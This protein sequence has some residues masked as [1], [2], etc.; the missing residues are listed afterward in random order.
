[1]KKSIVKKPLSLL[2]SLL[3]MLSV[4]GCLAFTASAAQ[5][6]ATGTC[7]A[8]LTWELDLEGTLTVRGTGD[9]T[10]Y[11]IG[12]F[13]WESIK[14]KIRNVIVK[15]GVTSVAEHAFRDNGSLSSLV[16][17]GHITVFGGTAACGCG[18]LSYV[19]FGT[20]DTLASWA[21]SGDSNLRTMFVTG[22]IGSIGDRVFNAVPL[23]TIFGVPGTA[24]KS[25]AAS[26][27]V[28]FFDI[29]EN[30]TTITY[31]NY[32]QTLVTDVTLIASL[33]AVSKSWASYRYYASVDGTSTA[34]DWMRF[35]DFVC[36][37][38]KY[39]AV[40]FDAYRPSRADSVHAA[41][42]SNQDENGYVPGTVYYFKYEPIAW[43]ILDS[44]A[45]LLLS[46]AILDAQM[47]ALD[48]A[49]YSESPIRAWL[50]NDFYGTAFTNGQKENLREQTLDND[51][52]SA[53]MDKVWLPSQ[54]DLTNSAY[55]FT[56]ADNTQSPTRS[57]FGTDYAKCMGL[58]VS[59]SAPCYWH[60][61]S[62]WHLRGSDKIVDFS[63]SFSSGT[64][65]VSEYGVR[66]MICLGS[67]TSDV[68]TDS[69]S[70]SAAKHSNDPHAFG[71]VWTFDV[72]Q[73]T[74]TVKPACICC[75]Y[76]SSDSTSVDTALPADDVFS[77]SAP[78]G[79]KLTG[80]KN[81]STGTT[82]APGDSFSAI[83][84]ETFTA[85]WSDAYTVTFD[86]NGGS[87]IA[88]QLVIPY[89]NAIEPEAPV[90]DGFAFRG[91]KRD[92]YTAM[93]DFSSYVTENIMLRAEWIETVSYGS[94]RLFSGFTATACSGSLTSSEGGAKLID[95]DTGTKWC[96][97]NTESGWIEF[98]SNEAF[99]PTAYVL[100]TGNDTASFPKRNPLSWSV[101]AKKESTDEWVPLE[102][103]VKD[104]RL[105]AYN[106]RAFTYPL[107]GITESY[108]YFR[109][110]FYKLV[111][112]QIFQ[113]SEF[114]FRGITASDYKH[115]INCIVNGNVLTAT[116]SN[117]PCA[118][119]TNPLTLTLNAPT[120]TVYGDSGD[121][122]ATLTGLDTFNAQLGSSIT[123][124]SI[125]YSANGSTTYTAPTNAGSYT[126]LLSVSVNGSSYTIS[127][128]YIIAK[129]TP[130][131][132][133][134]TGL[135]AAYGDTLANVTLPEGWAW[136]DAPETSVGNAGE[137]T[138][139]ATFTPA[140]TANYNTVSETLTVAVA[141][142]APEYT[143]PEGLT[144][145][146]GKTL[147][148]IE[149]P[150]GW[151][152]N[153]APETPVGCLGEHTFTAT[154]TPEDTD[155]YNTAEAEI[156]V[157]VYTDYTFVPAKEPTCI[158]AGNS[159]Y[160]Y[161]PANRTYYVVTE[162][163][164]LA[165]IELYTTVIP[166]T[167]HIYGTVGD[168]RFTCT[169]CGYVDQG[170]KEDAEYEDMLPFY[171]ESFNAAKEEVKAACDGRLQ[172]GDSAACAALVEN[173][174]RDIDNLPYD[175]Y[176]TQ[177]ENKEAVYAFLSR[178]NTDLANQ[179]MA[180]H[181]G[182]CPYCGGYHHGS[183]IGIL[184]AMLYV[185][186]NFFSKLFFFI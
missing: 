38:S 80:W 116:C 132:T 145:H 8:N 30:V 176:K 54:S 148:D 110:E 56:P 32:P 99:I 10:A 58:F 140:D 178:L 100:T 156:A 25:W 18:R 102:T 163:N 44:A 160:Y 113:L 89:G 45:G 133:V 12:N 158:R 112:Q 155:N 64:A 175:R 68:S 123:Q 78:A 119:T 73:K 90:K 170:R 75:G 24:I 20:V 34:G 147:A 159:A 161:N 84:T 138:F 7:G 55:G 83:R 72:E 154:F 184:H 27:N 144:V 46:D 23:Q 49:T 141:K 129:A 76:E 108:K 43:R 41:E 136:N 137:H 63:G 95:N 111:G 2:L 134:P 127:K 21:F 60:G 109:F 48:T 164:E 128:A 42:N 94:D 13:P 81:N 107:S 168:A 131:Y 15:D 31:G 166:A 22:D 6:I 28:R 120:K 157:T 177:D 67:V 101:L 181:A 14:G 11:G 86:S 71:P 77:G 152:W 37:G 69:T 96:M 66:P 53:T 91:W 70:Y 114:Q 19:K 40:I 105:R 185:L 153:D 1:M 169:V 59:N 186:R 174:K 16:V 183:I 62:R 79:K 39:R 142:A 36:D 85:Q 125:R 180:D 146:Y 179:R 165:E 126:A 117:D 35:A 122:N 50:A 17:E 115:N 29:R 172:E 173:T 121:A 167:G 93:Y 47:Y 52:E 97:T 4:F 104:T 26:N 74:A 149:L 5:V 65:N 182:A 150:E 151:A 106:T 162:E 33:D 171:L 87:A 98:Y 124:N 130:E 3:M 51:G 92:G 57:A 88:S 103:I 61:A 118:W 135:A 9:M 143:V 82:Y 139:E